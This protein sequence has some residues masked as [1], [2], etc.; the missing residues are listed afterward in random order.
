MPALPE[1][2]ANWINGNRKEANRQF[3]R[4]SR[5]EQETFAAVVLDSPDQI[6]HLSYEVDGVDCDVM[7]AREVTVTVYEKAPA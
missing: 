3:L 6:V 1:T 7:V 4:L 2:I 5:D